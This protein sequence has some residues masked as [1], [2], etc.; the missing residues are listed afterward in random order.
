MKRISETEALLSPKRQKLDHEDS[1]SASF[2]FGGKE[3]PATPPQFSRSGSIRTTQLDT[4]TSFY[5]KM[6]TLDTLKL[7]S[8]IE[9]ATELILQ[10]TTQLPADIWKLIFQQLNT[11]SPKS[12]S[13]SSTY[14]ESL[15]SL[16]SLRSVSTGW[17]EMIEEVLVSLQA[18]TSNNAPLL[19]HSLYFSSICGNMPVYSFIR[20]SMRSAVRNPRFDDACLLLASFFDQSDLFNHLFKVPGISP[21]API[22]A[23]HALIDNGN[24]DLIDSILNDPRGDPTVDAQRAIKQ[25]AEFGHTQIVRR[26]LADPRVAPQAQHNKAI[27]LASVNGYFEIVEMLLADPRVDPSENDNYAIRVAAQ[28]GHWEVVAKLLADPRVSPDSEN[29]HALNHAALNGYTKVVRL[30]LAD[31]RVR[32][33]ADNDSV[34]R[35]AAKRGHAGIVE[36]LLADER[37]SPEADDNSSIIAAAQNGFIEVVKLLL[38]DKRVSPQARGDASLRFAAQNHHW[39]VVK[40]LIADVRVSPHTHNDVCLSHAIFNLEVCQ[41]LLKDPRVTP[42]RYLRNLTRPPFF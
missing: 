1:R 35:K 41:L 20:K 38:A 8:V 31:S 39:E 6:E 16:L 21:N 40:L 10:K 17:K 12:F 11:K 4:L 2:E 34:L 7:Q 28:R 26:L 18:S 23:F 27:R 29:N 25:A 22:R 3:I 32:P 15:Q 13:P 14:Y 37:V 42:T 24:L 33:D 36:L 5:L 9:Y 30:L 19:K